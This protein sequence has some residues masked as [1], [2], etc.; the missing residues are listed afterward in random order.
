MN[1]MK[2]LAKY[3][4]MNFKNQMKQFLNEGKSQSRNNSEKR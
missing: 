1:Y 3:F 4:T 2:Y